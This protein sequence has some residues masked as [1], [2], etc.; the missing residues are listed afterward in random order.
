MT[1]TPKAQQA[2]LNLVGSSTFGRYTKISDE[3]TYNMFIS[4]GWLVNYAG[5]KHVLE[6][7]Q[8]G[9]GR[10]MFH[11]IRGNFII[12][13]IGTEIYKI[14]SG[15]NVSIVGSIVSGGGRVYI[16]EN[17][18]GQICLTDNVNVY[19]YHWPTFTFKTQSLGISDI[20]PTY[21]TYHN[22]FFLIGNGDKSNNGAPWYVFQSKAGSNDEIELIPIGGQLALENKPDSALAPIRLPGKGNN[23][24][25]LGST[26]GA[27]FTQTGGALSYTRHSSSNVDYGC[28][29]VDTIAASDEIVCWLSQN[30]NNAPVIMVT[31]GGSPER[32]SS[33]GIDYFL[34]R[35]QFPEDS[36]GFFYRQDGH[37]FYQLT[38]YNPLDNKTITYDFNT[39]KFYNL[40]DEKRDYFPIAQIVYFNNKIYG[41]SLRDS[42]LYEI[43]SDITEFEYLNETHAIPRTRICKSIRK[44]NSERMRGNVLLFWIEQGVNEDYTQVS[45]DTTSCDGI[46]I[47]EDAEFYFISEDGRVFIQEDSDGNCIEYQPRVDVRFSKT[48][49]HTFS[50]I[51]AYPL[52]YNAHFRNQFRIN[53]LGQFNELIMQFD[54]WT[55]S[56]VI[57]GNGILEVY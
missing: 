46:F 48:G 38:F 56:R 34:S 17:L 10:G 22:T 30:E 24:M 36:V 41:I 49:G 42:N 39:K 31:Q 2:E 5:Y 44:S 27:Y 51:V 16:D 11:S 50:T 9:I 33:D 25:V 53:K 29:N 52:N 7:S 32:I 1:W 20:I 40:I 45:H 4:D 57:A 54:F 15:L 21:V 55:K 23:I 13:V 8:S 18:N 26:V 43:S 37:L 14:D 3:Q 12:V 35:V 19:I 28:V 47:T 6:I